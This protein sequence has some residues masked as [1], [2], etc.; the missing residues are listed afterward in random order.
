MNQMTDRPL[1]EALCA[2][3]GIDP[4]YTDAFGTTRLA[5]DATLQSL[6]E[7]MGALPAQPSDPAVAGSSREAGG[8]SWLAPATVVPVGEGGAIELPL[9]RPDEPA[10]QALRWRLVQEDGTVCE[11]ALEA[12]QAAVRWTGLAPGYHRFELLAQPHGGR[13]LAAT[14]IV[15]HPASCLTP[16]DIA[17]QLRVWGPVVQLYAVR[18]ARNWGIGDFGDLLGVVEFAAE[19]GAGMVG[20]NP[21]HALFPDQ[22]AAASP[23]SPSNRGWLNP[24]YLDVGRVEGFDACEAVRRHVEAPAFEARLA[25][26][27]ATEFVDYPA[28]AQAKFE[29]LAM[30]WR[31]F[32]DTHLAHG[33][34]A[35]ADFEAFCRDGGEPLRTHALFEAVQAHRHELDP[36]AWG[37]PAWLPAWQA[38][39]SAEV[40][41]FA[42]EH[43]DR[44]AYHAWLQWLCERQLGAVQARARALGM[45]IGLYRDLAV[46]V[47]SG[48][49]ETWANRALYALGARV[50][51]PPDELNLHG[52]DWGLPPMIP[53]QLRAAGFGPFI[54]LLRANMRHAGALRIDHVMGLM[55]LFW[56]PPG[57]APVEGTY[58]H[59]P[60]AELA[61]IV[62]L[63]SRRN[64]CLVVGEDLGTVPDDVRAVMAERGMLS[65]RPFYFERGGNGEFRSPAELPRRALVALGT[66]DLPTVRG[67]WRAADI[68]LRVALGLFPDQALQDATA[69]SRD[70]DR[71]ALVRALAREGLLGGSGDA[72]HGADALAREGDP[73]DALVAAIHAWLARTPAALLA[74]QL[75]DAFGQLEQVNLPGTN[76]STYPNWRRKL[77]V[78]LQDWDAVPLLARIVAALVD[79]RGAAPRAPA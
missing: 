18:S 56:V 52:Q 42:R 6:C 31:W 39:D 9:R 78:A 16:D 4:A 32:A 53:A 60:L 13:P 55:R 15:A 79:G 35:A 21:L 46:G 72:A 10:A 62:A 7:A 61:G 73:D 44:V 45:P 11:G 57:A 25:G 68:R 69:R 8:K 27:R 37:W 58:V 3:L 19:A 59:Y 22:P 43:A 50:G 34:P 28:V 75:E 49:S 76:E 36:G 26:L 33:T 38:A 29:V 64:G 30:L 40:S 47:A 67:F 51:A 71:A 77:P 74:F 17:P 2:R 24:L 66:H 12:G 1:L 23:Y 54:E 41:R 20:V 70:Q 65:Y 63:E 48:G 14:L 5:S